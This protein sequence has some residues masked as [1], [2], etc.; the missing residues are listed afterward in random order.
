M[1]P[2]WTLV[3]KQDAPAEAA[4]TPMGWGDMAVGEV[5]F[6]RL[7]RPVSRPAIAALQAAIGH[8]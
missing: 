2:I 4:T 8:T 1:D 3:A 5:L 6:E 7:A